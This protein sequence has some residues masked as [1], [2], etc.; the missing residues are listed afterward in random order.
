MK[1]YQILKERRL[2]L[3]LSIQQMS[4]QIRLKPEYVRAIEENQLEVF[5]EKGLSYFPALVRGYCTAIGVNWSVIEREVYDNIQAFHLSK[6]SFY[7]V[8]TQL[9]HQ[10]VQSKSSKTS[11]NKKKAKK[12]NKTTS[13]NHVGTKK[14]TFRA[15]KTKRSKSTRILKLAQPIKK[16]KKAKFTWGRQNRLSRFILVSACGAILGLFGM[17][18][19]AQTVA[20]NSLVERKIA[21]EKELLLEEATTQRLADDFKQR[22]YGISSSTTTNTQKPTLA[23][24]NTDKLGTY[25]LNGFLPSQNQI[26]IELFCEEPQEVRMTWNGQSVFSEKVDQN[27][28]YPLFTSKDGTLEVTFMKSSAKNRIIIDGFEIGHEYLTDSN[29]QTKI[30]FLLRFEEN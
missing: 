1:Y 7:P 5:G 24:H 2:A 20:Q 26:E 27:V 23:I 11:K 28:T 12:K 30:S 15:T 10:D 19:F 6:T 4:E 18:Y 21:R 16:S 9:S 13:K 25:T 29:G 22:K 8:P 17:N 3:N 14:A